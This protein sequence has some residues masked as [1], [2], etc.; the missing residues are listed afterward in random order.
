MGRGVRGV[1]MSPSLYIIEGVAGKY[2]LIGLV[3]EFTKSII[4]FF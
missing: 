3:L 1:S 2:S 4:L